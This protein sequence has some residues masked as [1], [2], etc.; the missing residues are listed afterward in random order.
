MRSAQASLL[1]ATALAPVMLTD[2]N[3]A[4]LFATHLQTAALENPQLG[5]TARNDCTPSIC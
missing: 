2:L 5:L 3:G 4:K 1:D